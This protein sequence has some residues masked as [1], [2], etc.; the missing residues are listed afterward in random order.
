M[1]NFIF[2]DIL[3]TVMTPQLR[4]HR[5]AIGTFTR[6]ETQNH[7]PVF[8][9]ILPLRRAWAVVKFSV[10]DG[11]NKG[12]GLQRVEEVPFDR[13]FRPEAVNASGTI[14]PGTVGRL[15]IQQP[16]SHKHSAVAVP[17]LPPRAC[18]ACGASGARK[19]CS[20]CGGVSYCD[21]GCQTKHWAEHKASCKKA[22][23]ASAATVVGKEGHNSDAA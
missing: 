18:A 11:P 8:M 16:P 5:D 3:A 2:R 12:C 13:F 1:S 20:V 14:A 23:E 15:Y 22:A 6:R 21:R 4:L 9:F 10:P 17:R 7:G 19:S